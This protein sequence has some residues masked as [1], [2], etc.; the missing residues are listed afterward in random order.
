MDF[1][2]GGHT[3]I[4]TAGAITMPKVVVVKVRAAITTMIDCF[5]RYDKKNP[6]AQVG[7]FIFVE[8]CFQQFE[9]LLA[10][11]VILGQ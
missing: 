1:T 11:K 8:F 2:V 7:F 9:L 5:R 4:T 3:A 6:A 10:P